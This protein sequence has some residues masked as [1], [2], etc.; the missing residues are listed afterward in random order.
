[1]EQSPPGSETSPE[2]KGISETEIF[3]R[4]PTFPYKSMHTPP[5]RDADLFT[6]APKRTMPVRTTEALWHVHTGP[7]SLGSHKNTQRH[8]PPLTR[9]YTQPTLAAETHK[10]AHTHTT[11]THRK[12]KPHPSFPHQ[13]GH[14]ASGHLS[15]W[16]QCRAYDVPDIMCQVGDLLIQKKQKMPPSAPKCQQGRLGMCGWLGSS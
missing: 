9:M 5:S 13:L 2:P 4:G 10:A 14:D 6:R 1:M 8:G 11:H 3:A 15:H 12:R 7:Q 16:P